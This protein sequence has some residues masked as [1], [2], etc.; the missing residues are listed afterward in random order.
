[1]SVKINELLSG[2]QDVVLGSSGTPARLWRL[3]LSYLKVGMPRWEALMDN[4]TDTISTD[5]SPAARQNLKGN[6]LSALTEDIITWA[7]LI[8]GILILNTDTASIKI[9]L[10]RGEETKTYVMD[11]DTIKVVRTRGETFSLNHVAANVNKLTKLWPV[12]QEDFTITKG[13]KKLLD[14]YAIKEY[15]R[16]AAMGK[17]EKQ[18]RSSVRSG[19]VRNLSRS[20][21]SWKTFQLGLKVLRI[22]NMYI[23]LTL[24]GLK[25]IRVHLS[26]KFQH[27][28]K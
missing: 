23:T 25:T 21:I 9:E 28:E 18:T 13:W 10:S 16:L 14:E 19:P 22:E 17:I 2:S 27:G 24:G 11:L 3:M 1:M 7:N 8:K 20:E 15:D 5:L 4:F 12:I 6:L 26:V